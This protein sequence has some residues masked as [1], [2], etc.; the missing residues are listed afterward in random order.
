MVDGVFIPVA[1]IKYEIKTNDVNVC[2]ACSFN[3]PLSSG[4]LKMA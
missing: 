2:F 1:N 4:N 3:D